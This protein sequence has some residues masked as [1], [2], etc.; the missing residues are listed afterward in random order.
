MLEEADLDPDTSDADNFPVFTPFAA[1]L[2]Y[3][4]IG[5]NNFT[6][7]PTDMALRAKLTNVGLV[8]HLTGTSPCPA[9]YD[10]GLSTLTASPGTLIPPFTAPGQSRPAASGNSSVQFYELVV[11]SGTG[12]IT[13]NSTA[14][15]PDA[16]L[17]ISTEDADTETPGLQV[18]V[19]HGTRNFVNWKVVAADGYHQT[20]YS[21]TI[22]RDD[23]PAGVALLTDLTLSSEVVG[24]VQLEFNGNTTDYTVLVPYDL[25]TI[26]VVAT[27]LDPDAATPVIKI[28]D[29]VDAD[30]TVSLGQM[31]DT[32]TVEVTA[33]DG[34]TKQ[35]Y[36]VVV[37]KENTPPSLETATV[38]TASLALTYDEDL[39]GTSRYRR[40]APTPSP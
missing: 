40:P 23:P 10:D 20:S 7:T 1:S 26:T 35:N 3:L 25:D 12:R 16:T 36:T 14:R 11:D 28:N 6:T 19:I 29:V 18:D 24:D 9:A 37:T 31:T 27:P 30:G 39:D 17:T 32:I 22:I 15:D 33:E 38:N 2:L 8:L 13:F 21:L 5:A 34:T 4:D